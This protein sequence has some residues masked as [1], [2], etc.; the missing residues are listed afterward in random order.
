MDSESLRKNIRNNVTYT[1]NKEL[2]KILLA[3]LGSEINENI[4]YDK[5]YR[6]LSAGNTMEIDH[7]LPQKPNKNDKN[8]SYYIE[9]EKVKFKNNQ[10]FVED[11][12]IEM[13]KN[14]FYDSYLNIIGNL[15]LSWKEDN[16]RKSNKSLEDIEILKVFDENINTNKQI[17]IRTAKII[18]KILK[19]NIFL[20]SKN[21]NIKDEEKLSIIEEYDTT[22]K[23]EKFEPVSFEIL[24]EKYQLESYKYTSLLKKLLDVIYQ[25]EDEK[26]MDIAKEKFRFK[27]G[28]KVFISTIK[29]DIPQS[30]SAYSLEDKI[31]VDTNSNSKDKIRLIFELINRIGLNQSDFKILI[32]ER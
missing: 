2:A 21:I 32:K 19:A 15:R 16:R 31:F 10:D 8:F 17:N 9:G 28:R 27:D 30:E 5:L 1:K 25:L 26:L 12:T 3:Y 4:D 7:I 14:E 23:Y 29:E 6:K 20:N 22:I 18:E 13:L 11:G 24:E